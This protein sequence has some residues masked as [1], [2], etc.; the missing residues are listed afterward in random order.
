MKKDPATLTQQ[1]LFDD[2]PTTTVHQSRLQIF[3]PTRR[4][5]HDVLVIETSWGTAKVHGR[6]G[7]GH[8][9]VLEAIFSRA[10]D[11]Q[12]LDDGRIQILV[13]PHQVR[14]AAGGD[15]LS[16]DQLDKM[17]KELM[18]VV[19][20]MRIKITGLRCMG[21]IIDQ[22]VESK[23]TAPTRPGAIGGTDRKMWRVDIPEGFMKLI[24]GDL[25][26][27]YDPAPIARL[28]N[29]VSQAIARHI[30]TH[31]HEPSGGWTVDGLIEAVGAGKTPKQLRNRRGDLKEDVEGLKGLGITIEDG[32]IKR[33]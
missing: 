7:Q 15:K 12:I 2:L 30:A 6:I 9:D 3:Q 29:G 18:A 26:L 1:P 24:Q 8:A 10:S 27:H 19:I 22:V 16:G 21:H 28:T 13:D 17:I 11:H 5:K 14:M 32:R 31:K 25:H 23:V 33:L 20:D 4:P